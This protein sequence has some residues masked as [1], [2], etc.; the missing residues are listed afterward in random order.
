MAASTP[1]VCFVV[2]PESAGGKTRLNWPHIARQITGALGEVGV[3]LTTGPG[4]GIAQTKAALE[5]GYDLIVSVGGDGTNNEVMNGFFA[6]DGS[7]HRPEASFA[8]YPSGTGGDLRR[9][10]START[11][12]EL[13]QLIKHGEER[14]LDVGRVTFVDHDGKEA[15]RF[16]LNI[17]SFGIS[18][19]V[20]RKVSESSKTFG[21]TVTFYMA[22]L[23]SVFEFKNPVMTLQLDA[24]EPESRVRNLVTIANGKFFGGGMKIAPEAELDDGRFEIVTFGD[25][26]RAEQVLLTSSLY[27][28]THTQHPKITVEHASRLVAE[29]DA[30][31]YLDID[32]EGPGCLPAT[33]ELLPKCFRFRG[34]PE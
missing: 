17:A 31:V 11:V 20:N 2:N 1:A 27:K 6:P 34:L 28:G 25:M 16:F 21:G 5:E 7:L 33:F 15:V 13:L 19:L 12:P 29:S 22:S 23:R 9:S 10:L 3:R 24:A 26:T 32:G 8:F 4:D 30:P 14:M 18:A